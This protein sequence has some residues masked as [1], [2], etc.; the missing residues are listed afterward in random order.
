MASFYP[1]IRGWYQDS[2]SQQL[3][4]IVAVDEKSGMIE[5][6]LED[7]SI[8]EY[9]MESWK[10]LDV[11]PA[12]APENANASYGLP[13]I[14]DGWQTNVDLS[15]GGMNNPLEFIEGESYIG[16]FDDF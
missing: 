1:S 2:T 11:H 8:D 13:S 7:G 6:Q 16:D 12:A 5:I 10:Q 3:F 15:G 9:D 14:N 4:E